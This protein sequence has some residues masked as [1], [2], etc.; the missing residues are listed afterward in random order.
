M[1]VGP[2]VPPDAPR[3]QPVA[4]PPK[5]CRHCGAES[6]TFDSSCPNCGRSYG[7]RTGVTVAI[8]AA[9]CAAAILLLGGC[10]LL[11]ALGINAAN[12]EIDKRSITRA[13]FNAIEPGQT[14]ASVRAELGRPT[15]EKTFGQPPTHCIDYPQ[16]DDGLFGLGEY[17]FCFR[18]GVLVRKAVD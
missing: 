8:I 17:R 16:H 13:Q 6:E 15:S 4:P 12:D 3:G 18:D 11:I 14:E 2:V 7:Q 1:R 9:A 5:R 10:G